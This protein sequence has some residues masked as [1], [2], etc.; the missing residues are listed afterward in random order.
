MAKQEINNNNNIKIKPH[1]IAF[2]KDK[3]I[4][5]YI[6]LFAYEVCEVVIT[7]LKVV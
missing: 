4:N 3:Q 1:I 7:R 6:R 2:T 5:L